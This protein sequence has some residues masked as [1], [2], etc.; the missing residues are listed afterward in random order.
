[1]LDSQISIMLK[2]NQKI[3]EQ[4][5]EYDRDIKKKSFEL[6]KHLKDI[7]KSRFDYENEVKT[8]EH[9]LAR[10]VEE[11]YEN[12]MTIQKERAFEDVADQRFK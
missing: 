3:E 7:S 10:E 12:Q 5:K 9:E 1:V 6:E 2:Q 4:G 11:N 8:L